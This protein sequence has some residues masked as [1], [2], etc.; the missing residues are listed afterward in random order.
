MSGWS[1]IIARSSTNG[2][3]SV[4]YDLKQCKGKH[5]GLNIIQK[6]SQKGLLAFPLFEQKTT[7]LYDQTI[8]IIVVFTPVYRWNRRSLMSWQAVAKSPT[9]A[10][11][12]RYSAKRMSGTYLATV[13]QN[14]QQI[15]S[16]GCSKMIV[17]LYLWPSMPQARVLS[18][19]SDARRRPDV[20]LP[21]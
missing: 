4:P 15:I 1:V 17:V 13:A 6:V 12:I 21:P 5:N 9:G 16:L 2:S 20:L 14:D 10:L 11:S 8:W 3:V 18:P 7:R 19:S